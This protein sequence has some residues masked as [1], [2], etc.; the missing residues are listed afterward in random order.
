[1][2]AFLG[3]DALRWVEIVAAV[4]TVLLLADA[5]AGHYR[6]GFRL[7]V[8]YVPFPVGLALV[9]ASL[10]AAAAPR[11]IWS[12]RALEAAGWFAVAAGLLGFAFHHLYGV[13]RAP[14][15]YRFLLHHL[16]YGPPPLAPLGLT[17]AGALALIGRRGLAAHPLPADPDPRSAFFMWTAVVLGGLVAQSAL[18]HYRGAFNNPL[19]YLPF[20]APAAAIALGAWCAWRP[21]AAALAGLTP[22]LW[23]TFLIG[24]VGLGMHL[25]GFDRQMGGLY[26]ALFNW[27]EGPP[28]FAPALLSATAAVG[29]IAACLL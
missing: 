3:L 6:S 27:L 29:L 10:A 19:M 24:F 22:A 13:R 14:G 21:T 15:G 16:M 17:A 12:H 11:S 2:R 18:L 7:R 26:L 5:F 9:A 4:F 23:V 28:A 20:T 8:Q 25:R 1:M